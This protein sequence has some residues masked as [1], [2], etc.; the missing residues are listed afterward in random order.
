MA[1]TLTDAQIAELIAEPKPLPDDFRRRTTLR[2]KRGHAEAQL[3]VTGDAGSRFGLIFRRSLTNPLSFS[4]I[5]G[6]RPPQ[7]SQIFRLRRY[8]G[9]SHEHRNKIEGNQFYDFHVHMATHRYQELGLRE[10]GYAEPSERFAD[11][12]GAFE[13]LIDDCGFRRPAGDTMS[14]FNQ[15]E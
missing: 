8:N 10:D 1:V 15:G 13:C 12:D 11:M 3:D 4:V 9:K 5:L 6:Y 7:S 14:L 2:E